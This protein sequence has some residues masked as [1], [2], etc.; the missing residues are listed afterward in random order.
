M[1]IVKKAG[2]LLFLLRLWQRNIHNWPVLAHLVLPITGMRGVK[3]VI[4]DSHMHFQ[5]RDLV[6][7]MALSDACL[8]RD[9]ERYGFKVR[10]GWTII[11]AGAGIGSFAIPTA[12]EQ[13]GCTIAAFEPHPETFF[14]LQENI[15]QNSVVNVE[16]F[17]FAL[18]SQG[19]AKLY[20]GG[21]G[22]LQSST[23]PPENRSSRTVDVKVRS[24]ESIVH[25]LR[26]PVDLLKMDCEGA[27]YEVLMSAPTEC[28]RMIHRICL[29]YHDLVTE[30]NHDDLVSLLEQLHYRVETFPHR[31]CNRIGY[32][33]AIK[34]GIEQ[35]R[36]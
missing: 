29:E 33:R 27:E 9:Y 21:H 34:R 16:P 12:L 20:L 17:P 3:I 30:F 19:Q 31:S 15:R 4:R 8:L 11:D 35:P 25:S 13:P 1:S 23:I 24:L 26:R 2:S 10:N 14:L 18:G 22:P 28:F 6:D 7:L 36:S 5:V 32:L